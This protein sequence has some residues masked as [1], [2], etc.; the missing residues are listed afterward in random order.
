MYHWQELEVTFDDS[1]IGRHAP[2]IH[3]ISQLAQQ[4]QCYVPSSANIHHVIQR[5]SPRSA[6]ENLLLH[7]SFYS[8]EA[9]F[10]TYTKYERRKRIECMSTL[11]MLDKTGDIHAIST[12][13]YKVNMSWYWL[14][15]PSLTNSWAVCIAQGLVQSADLGDNEGTWC[16]I[17]SVQVSAELG[18]LVVLSGMKASLW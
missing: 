12:Q 7:R 4:K 13:P 5:H 15:T 11:E 10:R 3:N 16:R 8:C 2:H 14:E 17:Y 1:V 18:R 6:L 9:F